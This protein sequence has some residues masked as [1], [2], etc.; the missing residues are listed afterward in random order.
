MWAYNSE[1]TREGAKRMH[2]L[3]IVSLLN[4]K[5]L[6]QITRYLRKASYM[7]CTSPNKNKKGAGEGQ[8]REQKN[9]VLVTI[10]VLKIISFNYN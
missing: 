10:N 4:I 3:L 9:I 7:K 2:R 1:K 6:T 8:Y 5:G